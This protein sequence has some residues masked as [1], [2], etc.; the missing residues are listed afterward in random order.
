[1]LLRTDQPPLINIGSGK[2]ISIRELAE[3]IC[4][5]L[6]YSG[7]L[8][9]NTAQPDGTPQKLMDSS[10]M[11]SLGWEPKV[12]LEEGIRRTYAALR[13]ALVAAHV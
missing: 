6:D 8:T 2:D 5:L 13:G 4:R 12:R 7:E 3:L 11:R 9:F 1:M 10:R